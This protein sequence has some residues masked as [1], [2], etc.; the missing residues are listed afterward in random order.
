M[1]LESGQLSVGGDG[2]ELDAS[3]LP[4]SAVPGLVSC[5]TLETGGTETLEDLMTSQLQSY[6]VQPRTHPEMPGLEE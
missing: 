1:V 6:D 5:P 2:Y 4:S 3:R